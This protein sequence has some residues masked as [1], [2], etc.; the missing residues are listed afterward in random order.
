MSLIALNLRLK[1]SNKLA[2]RI[3]AHTKQLSIINVTE[4]IELLNLSSNLLK[5]NL[6]M[7]GKSGCESNGR[8]SLQ[9]RR[10]ILIEIHALIFINEKRSRWVFHQI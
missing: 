3:L 6:N 2:I 10:D 9:R 5:S 7:K 8:E 4:N 1:N